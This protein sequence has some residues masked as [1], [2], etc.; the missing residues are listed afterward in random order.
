MLPTERIAY[1]PISMRERLRLPEGKRLVV[2][3]S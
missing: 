2:W 3:S 1:S